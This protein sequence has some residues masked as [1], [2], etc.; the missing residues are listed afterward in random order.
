MCH[1]DH[2]FILWCYCTFSTNFCDYNVR[3]TIC[4]RKFQQQWTPPVCCQQTDKNYIMRQWTWFFS[5]MLLR[6]KT[7]DEVEDVRDC[8]MYTQYCIHNTCI[9]MCECLSA[10]RAMWCHIELV[11]F[12]LFFHYDQWSKIW[13]TDGMLSQF[14]QFKSLNLLFVA[15]DEPLGIFSKYTSTKLGSTMA[16][17]YVTE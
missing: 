1:P 8:S 14:R 17:T 10:V 15:S 4:F 7:R 9:Y 6:A 13:T 5:L 3:S 11:F 2:S 16:T 12:F